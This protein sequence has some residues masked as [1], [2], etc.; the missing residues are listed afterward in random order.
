V[1][2]VTLHFELLGGFSVRFEDGQPCTLPTRKAQAL[3]AYLALPAGRFHSREKLTALLWGD[4]AEVQAR[5]S[6]RQALSSIRRAVGDERALL[7]Q[8]DTIAL[9]IALVVVDVAE[10]ESALA[11]GSIDGLMRA[12]TLYKGD[13]LDGFSVDEP[14]FEEWRIVERERLRERALEG[15]T[16]LLRHQLLADG[17]EP[18]I[19]TTLRI[20]AMDP[21]Q[22]V[23]H[24]ALMK[25]LLRQG[26]RAAALQQYQVCVASLQRELGA[27]P[28]EETRELYRGILRAAGQVRDRGTAPAMLAST[29]GG[30]A[31]AEAPMIGRDAEL[32]RLQSALGQMLDAGGNVVVVSGEAGIGKSRL[33]QEFAADASARGARTIVGRCHETEQTLPLHP[34]IEAL[35]GDQLTLDPRLRDRLGAATSAELVRVFPELSTAGPQP[36][37]PGAQH[38]LLFD[39]LAELIATE[40]AAHPMIV[41]VE[42]VHWIDA[43]SARF[44]AYLGRRIH[45]L[46]V[47]VVASMRP[48]ELVDVTVLAQALAE[49]RKD[50]QLDEIVLR[51]LS[52]EE[53]RQLARHLGVRAGRD[54]NRTVDEI[55]AASEGNPFVVVESIR[56][57]RDHALDHDRRGIRLARR[58]QDFVASRLDRLAER[59]RHLVA[60]AAVIGR[61]FVFLLL[62]RAARLGERE[63]AETVEELVRRRVLQAVGDRL[64]FSHDWIRRVAYESLLPTTR[65]VLHGAVG[66]ALEELHHD[67]LDDVADQLGHHYSQAGDVRKA[68]PHLVRFAEVAAQRYALDEAARAFEQALGAVEQLP[69]AERDHARLD[70]GL[71]KAF[72]LSIIGRQQEILALLRS[73]APHLERVT[74]PLL[75]SE[76]YFRLGLTQHFLGEQGTARSAAERALAEGERADDGGA[77]GKALH[78]LSLSAFDTGRPREGMACATRAIP[79]LHQPRMRPWLGLV[80]HDLSLNCIGAGAL[81]QALEAARA[82]DEIGRTDRMPRLRAFAGYTTAWA[83]ALQGEHERA[84]EVATQIMEFSRDPMVA[85][86]VS[87]VMARARLEAGDAALAAT[88]LTGVVEQLRSTHLPAQVRHMVLLSE[89]QLATGNAFAARETATRALK[90]SEADAM[91]LSLGQAWRALGRIDAAAGAIADAEEHFTRAL[92]AFTD[93]EAAFEA[94]RT[95]MDRAPVRAK[96][97]DTDGARADLTAAIAAFDIA[98]APR[99]A[100]QARDLARSLGLALPSAA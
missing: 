70:V 33:I 24:R 38:A 95:M 8:G 76:Y 63:A 62:A 92:S 3:L 17:P 100:A 41:I 9:N 79:L 98:P 25:L 37:A 67:R 68:L 18:A 71:R 46:P 97:G 30:G 40:A 65:A 54:V 4:T 39:A 99:R 77:I 75:L 52:E 34:W 87:G 43:M 73:Q 48:E 35:R 53:T 56:E 28:E 6:F 10:L 1:G 14:P 58:V 59:P 45:R 78:V 86:L 85:A 81:E 51:S 26:R 60:A 36:M 83:L 13:L 12:A 16:R 55:W 90:L 74:D 23:V 7:T 80:H 69:A 84:L 94:A 32:A 11:D 66:D 22:E 50:G 89:A 49:L 27:E 29:A 57:M 21:L 19:Q 93:C 47:L 91:A 61:D 72:L 82:A 96:R 64:E 2:A 20:L 44:L 15:L 5:Q 88:M 42:D 31:A